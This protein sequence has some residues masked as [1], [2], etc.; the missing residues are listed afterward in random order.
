MP[1]PMANILPARVILGTDDHLET[2]IKKSFHNRR[3]KI[4]SIVVIARQD[5][6]IKDNE[7]CLLLN[8]A[9]QEQR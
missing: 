2:I 5:R 6:I 7:S 1:P 4:G 9:G 8:S 3:G